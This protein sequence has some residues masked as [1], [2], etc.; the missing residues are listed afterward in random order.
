MFEINKDTFGRPGEGVHSIRF[1]NIAIVDLLL[2]IA[3]SYLISIIFN[4]RLIY[5][6]I[7]IFLIGQLVHFHYGVDTTFTKL[8]RGEL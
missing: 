6:F 5:T 8:I 4:T 2:T 7:I 1:L 3:F